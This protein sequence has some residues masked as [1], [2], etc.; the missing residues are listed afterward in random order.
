MSD[1]A[2]FWI[3]IGV[4]VAAIVL[5]ALAGLY[6]FGAKFGHMED[7][8]DGLSAHFDKI[9]DEM[10][11]RFDEAR[12]ERKAIRVELQQLN[13]NFIQHLKDEHIKP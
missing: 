8:I 12:D 1:N 9:S 7:K 13:Q 6:H 10:N 11:R 3:T 2:K 4:P 5:T